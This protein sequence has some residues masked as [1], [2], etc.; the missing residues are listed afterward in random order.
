MEKIAEAMAEMIAS[1]QCFHATVSPEGV[2]DIGPKRSTRVLDENTLM[3]NEG[4]GGQTYRNLLAGSMVATAVVDREVMDGYRFLSR[5]ELVT[6]GPLY[7][8]AA[9]FSIAGG[10][11]APKAIVLLHVQKVFTLKAG[12][13]AGQELE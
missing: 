2:P 3:F 8:E 10:R 7:E 4:T 1:Q 11:P 13:Q 6:E 9:A 12:P 5:A